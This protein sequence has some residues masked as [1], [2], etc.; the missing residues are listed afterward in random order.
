MVPKKE[1][2]GGL[3]QLDDERRISYSWKLHEKKIRIQNGRNED[4]G[5]GNDNTNQS[6]PL[7]GFYI[8]KEGKN[9]RV[10]LKLH[11]HTKL[12]YNEMI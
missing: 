6:S 10:D 11:I 3:A 12:R 4:E 7:I 8:D 2:E 9:G 1:G 5:N